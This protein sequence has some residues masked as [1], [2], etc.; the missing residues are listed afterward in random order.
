[1]YFDPMHRPKTNI[2]YNIL[3]KKKIAM[4]EYL[5]FTSPS[6]VNAREW[7]LPQAISIINSLHKFVI[8]A[9]VKAWLPKVFPNS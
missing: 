4:I 1:M 3:I 8:I 9:G 6:F 2:I 7:W 5:Y